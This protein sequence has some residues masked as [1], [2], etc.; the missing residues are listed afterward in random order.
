MTAITYPGAISRACAAI[1]ETDAFR[2]MP[3][4]YLRVLIRIVKKINL[5]TLSAP[6][7]ASRA[8][9]AKESGKSIETVGRALRW[10]E[11]K[12]FIQRH[13]KARPG[14]RGSESPII[15]TK[16]LLMLLQIAGNPFT[17][18]GMKAYDEAAGDKALPVTADGSI[19]VTPKQSFGKQ[20]AKRAPFTK[21][22]GK[23]LPTDLAELCNQGIKAT[24]ILALM[25]EAKKAGK[26]LSDVVAATSKY[27]AA[28]QG[29]ELFAYLSAL[30]RKDR[31][32]A[33]EISETRKTEEQQQK[34]TYLEEKSA[35]MAGRKYQTPDGRMHIEVMG[36]CLLAVTE[37]GK[38]RYVSRLDQSW[39]D[40]IEAGKLRAVRSGCED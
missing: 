12:K 30:I 3:D 27:L 39:L 15:P 28:L 20:H 18:K 8:T 21:V 17:A 36:N 23:T 22:E 16:H 7:C 24:G 9:L 6:I 33:R 2:A 5:A 10:M 25:R 31:D 34:K 11:E 4:G 38:G 19:S 32:F 35:A 14:F 13:Q 26:R 1:D 37:R 40:A 29:R